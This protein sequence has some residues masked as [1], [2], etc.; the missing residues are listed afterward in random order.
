MALS[1]QERQALFEIERHLGP[2]S[3]RTRAYLRA[4]RSRCATLLL[5]SWARM[6]RVHSRRGASACTEPHT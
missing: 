2:L 4:L 3:A 6:R 1:E 5:R